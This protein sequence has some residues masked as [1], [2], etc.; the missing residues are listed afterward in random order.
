MIMLF[1]SANMR[2]NTNLIMERRCIPKPILSNIPF[3]ITPGMFCNA[4]GYGKSYYFDFLCRTYY[5]ACEFELQT[6]AKGT[7]ESGAG[8]R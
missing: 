1:S 2:I 7:A 3:S 8:V 4:A 6:E 5:N